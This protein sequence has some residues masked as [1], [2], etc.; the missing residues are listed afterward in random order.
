MNTQLQSWTNS[1]VKK[2]EQA[3]SRAQ[4]EVSKLTDAADELGSVAVGI[5]PGRGD[6]TRELVSRTAEEL[7]TVKML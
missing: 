4:T 3:C 1:E 5:F 7:R 6:A 2:R